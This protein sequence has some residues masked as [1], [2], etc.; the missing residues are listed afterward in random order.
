M[1]KQ[2]RSFIYNGCFIALALAFIGLFWVAPYLG[3]RDVPKKWLWPYVGLVTIFNI[4]LI[5]HDS[6][7]RVRSNAIASHK[8]VH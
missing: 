5:L 7:K 1:N 3:W 6:V 4:V 8:N 2:T